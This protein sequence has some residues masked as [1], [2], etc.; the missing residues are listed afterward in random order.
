VIV[1]YRDQRIGP[2]RPV[3]FTA[4]DRFPNQDNHS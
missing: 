1:Y 3:D 2:A 4:N